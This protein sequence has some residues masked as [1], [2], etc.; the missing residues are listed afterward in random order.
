MSQNPMSPVLET[1]GKQSTK[2]PPGGAVELRPEKV[3]QLIVIL[4]FE[5]KIIVEC[6]FLNHSNLI[7]MT[8][9]ILHFL[10]FRNFENS[11]I[12]NVSKIFLKK[13][14]FGNFRIDNLRT[15]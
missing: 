2:F 15:V 12:L 9:I 7:K 6:L 3:S 13:T 5:I 11:E 1:G 10:I 14:V 8:K 4:Q